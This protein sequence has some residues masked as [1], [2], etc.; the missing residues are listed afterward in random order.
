MDVYSRI[1]STTTI[2]TLLKSLMPSLTSNLI[3]VTPLEMVSHSLPDPISVLS[4]VS[5]VPRLGYN[6]VGTGSQG[7]VL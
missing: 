4:N 3:L 1:E 5:L 6:T 7:R 2:K